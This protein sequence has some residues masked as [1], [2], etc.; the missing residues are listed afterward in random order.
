MNKD[1]L[2]EVRIPLYRVGEWIATEGGVRDLGPE[3]ITFE[4]KSV[5]DYRFSS[6]SS[7]VHARAWDKA[8]PQ[9]LNAI[10]TCRLRVEGQ[11]DG[12]ERNPFVGIEPGEFS[13]K[14]SNPF[15]FKETMLEEIFGERRPPRQ[16][17]L[18]SDDRATISAGNQHFWG[19]I[20]ACSRDEVLA[21]WPASNAA[22]PTPFIALAEAWKE[23]CEAES[24]KLAD[25]DKSDPHIEKFRDAIAAPLS[26]AT[27]R[28]T[29]DRLKF[30]DLE[31]W[32]ESCW[33]GLLNSD[34]SALPM[35]VVFER[36]EFAALDIVKAWREVA[37]PSPI[38]DDDVREW[39]RAEE[40]KLGGRPPIRTWRDN[41]RFFQNRGVTKLRFEGVW[42]DM[43]P[44]AQAGR[45]SKN[46][47]QN[48]PRVSGSKE[49]LRKLAK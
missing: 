16:L 13:D 15:R 42:R 43:Y 33:P 22:A 31:D 7:P 17:Y 35:A 28:N 10:H 19:D 25:S 4:N 27:Y 36:E 45:P 2:P 8:L 32:F 9:L 3:L 5:P 24:A 46:A 23:F 21:L 44:N 39:L 40:K 49:T 34:L 37:S 11:R 20:R 47:P 14:A 12:D 30:L 38:T 18:Y 26:K 1:D 41:Q 48:V 6:R 29:D